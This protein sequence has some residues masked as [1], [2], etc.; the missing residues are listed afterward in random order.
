[1]HGS[2]ATVTSAPGS[3]PLVLRPKT[4]GETGLPVNM[5]LELLAKHFY[6]GGV[7][8]LKQLMDRTAL[9]GPIV[10]SLIQMLR[11][12]AQLEA[13]GPSE[14]SAGIRYALTDRGRL[15]ALDAQSRSGY[16]GPAPVALDDY[17]SVV[18]AQ[19]VHARKISKRRMR[20]AFRDV[21]VRDSVLDQ[22]GPALHS[23][24]AIL[25]YGAAGTGKTFICGKLA[26]VVGGGI[27]VPHA[28]AV[29]SSIVQIYDPVAH[30][31]ADPA[32]EAAAPDLSLSLSANTDPRFVYCNRPV[33][34]S[35][36]ELTLEMLEIQYDPVSKSSQAPAQLKA[37]NGLYIIDDLGRQRVKPADLLNRWIVPMEERVDYLTLETGQRFEVPSD[38]ILV[39]ST[40]M[41]PRSLSDDAFLRR[42]GYKIEFPVLAAEEYGAIWQ[43]VCESRLIPFDP[44]LLQFVFGLYKRD[45]R[46]LLPCQPRDLI[47]IALDQS[48]Y[49]EGVKA[50]DRGRLG[51]AWASYF[52]SPDPPRAPQ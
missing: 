12:E 44:E 25:I 36:G 40:N 15:F 11:K 41:D 39:F 14:T 34:V 13:L 21:V 47:G 42:L 51:F 23:S 20:A 28:I 30:E 8:D 7:M 2:S 52:V 49:E 37:T 50:I 19:T 9:A 1:V 48:I 29:G 38:V 27:L 4:L 10:E 45:D 26:R 22:L 16:V 46:P 6:R 43:Q 5:L 3:A 32:A 33:V 31:A 17:V 18:K 24:R 35:G